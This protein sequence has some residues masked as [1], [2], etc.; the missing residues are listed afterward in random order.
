MKKIIRFIFCVPIFIALGL[1]QLAMIPFTLIVWPIWLSMEIIQWTHGEEIHFF[2]T[3]WGIGTFPS[4]M[5][6]DIW[7]GGF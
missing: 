4:Q 7:T 3:C 1:L 6:R 5:M 2:E